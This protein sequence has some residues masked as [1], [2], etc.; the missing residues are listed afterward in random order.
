MLCDLSNLTKLTTLN[1]QLNALQT[2]SSD[3]FSLRQLR[4]LDL[5]WNKIESVPCGLSTLSQLTHL[6]LH[7]NNISS[8]KKWMEDHADV[9]SDVHAIT[10]HSP[11]YMVNKNMLYTNDYLFCP[12]DNRKYTITGI[13]L[14]VCML[15]ICMF[16]FIIVRIRQWAIAK[17]LARKMIILDEMD[18]DKEFDVFVSYASEEIIFLKGSYLNLKITTSKY[19]FTESTSL[20]VTQ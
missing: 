2:V 15:L 17:T 20:G 18:Q 12:N 19:V 7:H 10:C 8:A 1:L 5:S 14:G 6:D 13:V 9:I 3:L 16:S 11:K 4:G